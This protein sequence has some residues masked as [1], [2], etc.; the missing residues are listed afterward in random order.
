M[1]YRLQIIS[2]LTLLVAIAASSVHAQ[3]DEAVEA[4]A[5]EESAQN[6]LLDAARAKGGD[7]L[8]MKSGAIMGGVQILRSSPMSYEIELV[9]GMKPMVI[10]RRQVVSVEYDDIDLL[11][12]RTRRKKAPRRDVESIE[13]GKEL[14]PDFAEKLQKKIPGTPLDFARRDYVEVFAELARITRVTILIDKS[15]QSQPRAV[16]LW[17]IKVTPGMTL[18]DVLGKNWTDTFKTGKVTFELNKVVLKPKGAPASGTPQ[19]DS[20]PVIKLGN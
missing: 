9:P 8:I 2:I 18:L 7:I 20:L 15:L 4:D 13:G 5:A 11:R 10:P 14:A 3:D 6:D 17:T 19:P 16:R 12:E 1:N